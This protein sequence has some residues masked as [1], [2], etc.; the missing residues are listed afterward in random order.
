MFRL[1]SPD[2]IAERDQPFIFG[3]ATMP[4]AHTLRLARN[5]IG[6]IPALAAIAPNSARRAGFLFAP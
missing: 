5:R 2:L 6:S 1:Q 4:M 3:R